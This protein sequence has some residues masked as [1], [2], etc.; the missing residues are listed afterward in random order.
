MTDSLVSLPFRPSSP[1]FR[2]LLVVRDSAGYGLILAGDQP[3]YVQSVR[4]GGAAARAGARAKTHTNAGRI[5]A[6]AG[7]AYTCRGGAG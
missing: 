2:N 3:V 7:S 1:P 5:D 4:S 6:R